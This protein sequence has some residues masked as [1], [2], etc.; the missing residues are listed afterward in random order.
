MEKRILLLTDGLGN[1]GAER[2]LALLAKNLPIEWERKILS[3]KDGVFS[4]VI[5]DNNV[6]VLIFERTWRYDVSPIFNLL[7]VL[8]TWKPT[9]VHSWGWLS[10]AVACPICR[11]LRIPFIDGSI[12]IGWV[13]P[14][15][16]VRA[17]ITLALAN[18]VIANSHAGLEAWGI[19]PRKGRVV[20]NGLDPERS[21]IAKASKKKESPFTVVMAA[22]MSPMKDHETLITAARIIAKL[23]AQ[24]HFIVL[25]SGP[26]KT[27]LMKET[28]G[29]I[30]EGIMT[31]PDAGVEVFPYLFSANVGVLLTNPKLLAEGCSNAIIEYMICGLPVIC[32]DSGGNRELVENGKTGFII[33]PLNPDILVKKIVWLKE[34]PNIASEMGRLGKER[35][36]KMF[37]VEDYIS[38][39]LSVYGEIIKK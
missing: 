13:N 6:P 19:S 5:R 8:I 25:G 17:R 27:R 15:H 9:I 2:Q 39:T 16:T 18:R 29:L 37:T 21:N 10:S 30:S 28:S 7:H 35:A 36:M 22:R 31:F 34:N 12:R 33:P 1:G 32:S 3:L 4:K 24:W 14:N 20:Y 23:P 11:L 38:N 26:E